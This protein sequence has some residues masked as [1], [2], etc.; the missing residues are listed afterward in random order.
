MPLPLRALRATTSDEVVGRLRNSGVKFHCRRKGLGGRRLGPNSTAL[1]IWG[2]WGG[3]E[4]EVT[5]HM[6][7]RH[8]A[9]RSGPTAYGAVRPPLQWMCRC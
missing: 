5:A 3:L 6:Q 7:R 2:V 8:K 9:W 1:V 4:K